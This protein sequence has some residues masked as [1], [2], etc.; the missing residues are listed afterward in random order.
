MLHNAGFRKVA[1]KSAGP[2]GRLVRWLLIDCLAQVLHLPWVRAILASPYF[3]LAERYVIKPAFISRLL[4]ALFWVVAGQVISAGWGLALFLCVTVLV[5]SRLGRNVDELL[6]DWVVQTWHHIRIHIFSALFRL[7]RRRV[8][9]LAGGDRA[10]AL[11]RRRMAAVQGRRASD[12]HG[13]QGDSD[14]RCGGF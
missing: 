11:H 8:S 10:A 4:A 7:D 5:N 14:A 1:W 2:I 12:D 3:R 6:T 13:L 9:A